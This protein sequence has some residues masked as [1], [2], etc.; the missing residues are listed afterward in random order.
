M[1][2]IERSRTRTPSIGPPEDAPASLSDIGQAE[3]P[4]RRVT[5][6]TVSDGTPDRASGLGS[7]SLANNTIGIGLPADLRSGR[8]SRAR[9]PFK[10]SWIP[11]APTLG[12]SVLCRRSSWMPWASGAHRSYRAPPH[13]SC[14]AETH[15]GGCPR[16][17]PDWGTRGDRGHPPAACVKAAFRRRTCGLKQYRRTRTS[18]V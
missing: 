11:I 5:A 1:S 17:A 10:S 7:I 9:Q 12:R 14:T 13:P 2:A 6:K 8:R 3:R 15:G 18:W 16:R 4:S